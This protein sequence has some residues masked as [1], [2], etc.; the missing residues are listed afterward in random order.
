M[1]SIVDSEKEVAAVLRLDP[2]LAK[3]IGF[4]KL[5]PKIA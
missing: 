4:R 5:K 3:L 2:I 1:I